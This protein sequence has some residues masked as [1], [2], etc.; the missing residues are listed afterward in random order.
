MTQIPISIEP[1]LVTIVSGQPAIKVNYQV[2]L[3][4]EEGGGSGLLGEEMVLL[5][6]G[7]GERVFEL[8]EQLADEVSKYLRLLHGVETQKPLA[9][10]DDPLAEEPL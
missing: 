6:Q 3:N 1:V 2:R 9:A 7:N 8:A 4:P 5:D 10:L